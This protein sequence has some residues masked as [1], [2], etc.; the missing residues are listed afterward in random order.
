MQESMTIN[1]AQVSQE[2]LTATLL[3]AADID[4]QGY[5]K[6]L[7]EVP[8]GEERERTYVDFSPN[9]AIQYSI[10]GDVKEIE[11]WGIKLQKTY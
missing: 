8:P 5:E 9:T 11:N 1:S 7:E 4:W 2:N 6:P 10:N 3:K